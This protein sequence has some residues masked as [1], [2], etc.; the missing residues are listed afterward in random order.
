MQMKFRIWNFSF[1]WLK[2]QGAVRFFFARNK[3]LDK[4]EMSLFTK[5]Q[6]ESRKKEYA[7]RETQREKQP[8]RLLLIAFT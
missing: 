3:N 7:Y 2:A 5:L 1:A 4:R 6:T 8:N